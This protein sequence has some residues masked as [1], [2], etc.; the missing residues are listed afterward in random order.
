[1]SPA[2]AIFQLTTEQANFAI[3]TLT[4]VAPVLSGYLMIREK[5]AADKQRACSKDNRLHWR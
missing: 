4:V 5:Y 3:N 2:Y 1:M